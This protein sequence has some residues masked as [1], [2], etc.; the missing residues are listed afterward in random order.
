MTVK[1]KLILIIVSII[2]NLIFG[3]N[4]YQ[5]KT[6]RL[7]NIV[8]A[9]RYANV[10]PE[11][12]QLLDLKNEKS[13]EFK[14]LSNLIVDAFE[15]P[16]LLLSEKYLILSDT[17][18]LRS[19]YTLN[20]LYLK[21][22]ALKESQQK[23]LIDSLQVAVISRPDFVN[24]YYNLLFSLA[25]KRITPFDLNTKDVDLKRCVPND[26]TGQTILFMNLIS[27]CFKY[28][29]SEPNTQDVSH[30]KALEAQYKKYP[31]FNKKPFYEMVD[32]QLTDFQVNFYQGLGFSSFYRKNLE[33]YFLM[34]LGYFDVVKNELGESE[35][36]E[37]VWSKSAL[38][39]KELYVFLETSLARSMV[40]KNNF[41]NATFN[42]K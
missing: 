10:E 19:V 24:S 6:I 37:R 8:G 29:R 23:K 41:I 28:V 16:E 4:E 38:H 15:T 3:Q 31:T 21:S 12:K 39:I 11:E 20:A 26:T 27:T 25:G 1:T 13:K 32:F 33:S 18:A 2:P 40:E 22:F 34:L 5:N 17:F 7:H 35:A 30:L 36:Y 9:Y 42:T 14:F